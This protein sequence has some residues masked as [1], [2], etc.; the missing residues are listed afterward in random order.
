MSESV[1][2]SSISLP[3]MNSSLLEL[4][5]LALLKF[6]DAPESFRTGLLNTLKEEQI[7]TRIYMHR[8]KQCGLNSANCH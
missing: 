4:M 3:I 6:P 8:M 5:A 1:D 2:G 7:H